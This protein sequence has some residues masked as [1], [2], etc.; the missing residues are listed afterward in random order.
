MRI[1]ISGKAGS[2]KDT[3]GDMIQ[4]LTAKRKDYS[5][6]TK[7]YEIW[8]GSLSKIADLDSDW[9][10]KKYSDKLKD[11]VCILI[12]CTREQLEDQDFKD[13]PLSEEWTKWGIVRPSGT[14]VIDIQSSY[15][16]AFERK[17]N[18]WQDGS[19]IEEIKLTP[20][21]ILQKL[22]TEFGRDMLHPDVWVNALFAEYKPASYETDS[23]GNRETVECKWI[24]TDS[25]FPND[26]KRTRKM[27]GVLI[28]VNRTE[29]ECR[30]DEHV[31]ETALDDF[32]GWDYVIENN[33]TIE[34]L[35]AQVR[36]I[37]EKEGIIKEQE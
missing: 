6:L 25:R 33:G 9:Q 14:R 4:Y 18:L 11:M 28:R 15:E 24:I 32:N 1:S 8:K 34:E 3:V 20:R 19:T 23:N 29:C 16:K 26:V 31:S 10:I 12:G 7:G 2:G 13:T 30:A 17:E 5:D 21:N 36:T 37:L 35:I 27:G 22:G